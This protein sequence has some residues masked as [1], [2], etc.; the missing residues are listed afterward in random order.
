MLRV[1]DV[2]D[3]VMTIDDVVVSE[4]ID[5]VTTLVMDDDDDVAVGRAALLTDMVAG[6]GRGCAGTVGIGDISTGGCVGNGYWSPFAAGKAVPVENIY[7]TYKSQKFCHK[8]Y[9][10]YDIY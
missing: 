1:D 4:I 10:K 9:P 2:V 8:K 6:V 5:V 3:D 7:V